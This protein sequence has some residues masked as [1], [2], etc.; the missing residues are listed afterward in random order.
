M[1]VITARLAPT[2]PGSPPLDTERLHSSLTAFKGSISVGHAYIRRDD[3]GISLVL[4][5]IGADL[6]QAENGARAL[7]QEALANDAGLAGWVVAHCG[8]D[9]ISLAMDT[10]LWADPSTDT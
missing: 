2:I 8:A 9:L 6:P 1:Y 5:L 3:G 10:L 7:L 4:Y